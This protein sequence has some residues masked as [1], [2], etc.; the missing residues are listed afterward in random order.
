ME[1]SRLPSA[2]LGHPQQAFPPTQHLPCPGRFHTTTCP[3]QGLPSPGPASRPQRQC[4]SLPFHRMAHSQQ[5]RRNLP[6]QHEA[7]LQPKRP[8]PKEFP[9][10]GGLLQALPSPGN[11]THPIQDFPSQGFPIPAA[12]AHPKAFASQCF[13][14]PG[15]F[16]ISFIAE[17]NAFPPQ[18]SLPSP[19]RI[20]RRT[21]PFPTH[22]HFPLSPSNTQLSQPTALERDLD[23]ADRHKVTGICCADDCSFLQINTDPQSQGRQAESGQYVDS[24]LF[25]FLPGKKEI[26]AF[27]SLH[28]RKKRGRGER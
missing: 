14:T 1:P 6:H 9:S 21:H 25:H 26:C 10:L 17:P 20:S 28:L 5:P 19:A 15:T 24:R 7:F 27:L 8:R 18:G 11:G 22:S 12:I 2:R 16:P 3:A 4:P 13:Q 23:D